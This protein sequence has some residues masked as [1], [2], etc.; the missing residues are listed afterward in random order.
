MV[1]ER[2]GCLDVLD[3]GS[4]YFQL[5]ESQILEIKIEKKDFIKAARNGE[6]KRD[7]W[8][9]WNGKHV[10]TPAY[11]YDPVSFSS[12]YHRESIREKDFDEVIERLQL[13]SKTKHFKCRCR[14]C[15]KTR[16]YTLETLQTNPQF[17]LKPLYCSEKGRSV[18]ALDAAYNKKQKYKN[19]ESVRLVSDKNEV[20]PSDEYCE[21]WNEKRD[22]D[23]RKQ[24][25]KD[26][27]LIA[28]TP[29][30]FAENYDDD[31][32]GLKYESLDVL[33]CIS[34][35]YESTPIMYYT[36][37]HEKR[38]HDIIVYKQYRCRCYLCGKEMSVTCDKFGIYPPTE[39]GATAYH[40][41]WSKLSCDCHKISS[42]Q[43][44]VNKIL[45]DE[46]V[47]YRVEQEFPDLFGVSG[48]YK[49]RFDFA[50]L[51][52]NGSIKCLIEC[53]G[54]QHYEPVEE[55]GGLHQFKNQLRNDDLKRQYAESHHIPLYEISY[56]DKRI[57]R[58]CEILKERGIV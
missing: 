57:E 42:F 11:I 55:F 37:R 24:A 51:N 28:A 50:I 35:S 30:R 31:F 36:Q 10:I 41:Y 15:G 34:D 39:Y 7:D 27:A 22:K 5:I 25:E 14:K 52:S 45:I 29:R 4:E 43:W 46:G 12:E 40:G 6:L 21:K 54:E 38:Y 1:G 17:C 49:L 53:Q 32:A 44:I 18:S 48:E 8:H 23:L 33:E 13:D 2:Y 58:I 20:V 26:A 16:Y 47:P 3:D 9:G 56:K 19:N